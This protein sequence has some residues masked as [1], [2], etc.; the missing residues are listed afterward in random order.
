MGIHA[1]VA[2]DPPIAWNLGREG[3]KP[4]VQRYRTGHERFVFA[5]AVSSRDGASASDGSLS[6]SK[7]KGE[8]GQTS[9]ASREMAEAMATA[10]EFMESV[11]EFQDQLQEL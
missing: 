1:A 10:M 8:W 3:G 9:H 6:R 5:G 4:L 7:A 2:G 11:V